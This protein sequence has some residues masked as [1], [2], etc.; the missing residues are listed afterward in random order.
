MI[1]EL[2]PRY[3]DTKIPRYQDTKIPRYA[4]SAA[5]QSDLIYQGFKI[6]FKRTKI[7]RYLLF[8]LIRVGC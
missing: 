4:E 1:T 7:Q 3:Q 6:S 5:I 2:D 8:V